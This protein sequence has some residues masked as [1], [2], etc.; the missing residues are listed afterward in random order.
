MR[1]IRTSKKKGLPRALIVSLLTAAVV[2]GSVVTAV[3]NS[4][5]IT[6]YDGEDVYSF[7]MIGADAEGI[8]ARAETEG[9]EP[10][11][12][13]DECVF[14]ESSSVLTVQRNVRVSVKVDDTVL[15][16]VVPEESVLADVLAENDIELGESDVIEPKADTVLLSDTQAEIVRSNRVHIRAD[17]KDI[18]VDQLEGTVADA[19]HTAGITVTAADEVFPSEETPLE[20]GMSITVGRGLIITVA[21]DGEETVAHVIA[22][23]VEEAVLEAGVELGEED[24][25]YIVSGEEEILA[26]RDAGAADGVTLRVERIYKETVTES[27]VIEHGVVYEDVEGKYRDQEKVVTRGKNGEKQVTYEITYADG[28]EASRTVVSEEIVTEAVDEVIERGTERRADESGNHTFV[29]SAGDTVGYEWAITGECTA[30]SWLAGSVTST[31]E[32]VQYGYVAVDPRVIPYGSLLYITSPNGEWNYGYCY[33]MDTGSAAR[34]GRIIADLF[35]DSEDTC[36]AFGRRDMTVYVI[37]E[38]GY[39]GW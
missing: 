5:D 6:V 31:G 32:S 7:S 30:Y 17:G 13:I 10:L 3:A 21:A 38:G 23:D 26:D 20:D 1:H 22:H 39:H 12:T 2:L 4:V 14:S 27:Q 35:Y 11:S 34:S 18:T 28:V 8:I 16:L 37:Q 15:S 36:N 25:I 29:D 19:L 9:M 33:A 24:N